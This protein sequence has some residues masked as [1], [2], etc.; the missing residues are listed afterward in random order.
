MATT[1]QGKICW[2]CIVLEFCY[3]KVVAID[4]PFLP[5]IAIS[6]PSWAVVGCCF[7]SPF[8][9]R[10]IARG[11]KMDLYVG[12]TTA[13]YHSTQPVH[14]YE[15]VCTYHAGTK[16]NITFCHGRLSSSEIGGHGARTEDRE[17]LFFLLS[18]LRRRSEFRN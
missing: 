18:Q 9:I 13:T 12:F 1:F 10:K 5:N 3:G 6:L 11:C 4:L 7:Q 2:Q 16:T 17:L 8:R 15:G 14:F